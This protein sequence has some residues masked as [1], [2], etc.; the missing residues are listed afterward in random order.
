MRHED[1]IFFLATLAAIVASGTTIPVS[2]AVRRAREILVE[3]ER[4]TPPEEPR[5]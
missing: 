3:V 2:D 4:S 1:R 5:E